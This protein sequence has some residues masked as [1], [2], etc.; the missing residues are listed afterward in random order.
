MDFLIVIWLIYVVGSIFTS[1]VSPK[2]RKKISDG[3]KT[4]RDELN[5]MET[6]EKPIDVSRNNQESLT[7][8]KRNATIRQNNERAQQLRNRHDNKK[9]TINSVK[10]MT[11]NQ[12]KD[13]LTKASDNIKQVT[14]NDNSDSEDRYLTSDYASTSSNFLEQSS[15]YLETAD[16]YYEKEMKNTEQHLNE[17]DDWYADSS[18]ADASWMELDDR[19]VLDERKLQQAKRPS[20]TIANELSRTIKDQQSL[21]QMIIFNEII[22]K[23]KSLRR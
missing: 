3:V 7:D 13:S 4:M 14:S 23:P 19:E 20:N 16:E 10:N 22:H 9:N 2:N 11:L 6:V 8:S 15:E 5:Q 17:L 12:L 1:I 21:R 18:I